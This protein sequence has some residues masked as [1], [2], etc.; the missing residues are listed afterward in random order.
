MDEDEE[1]E[2]VM[3]KIFELTNDNKNKYSDIA[4]LFR[5]NAQSRAI[6]DKLI[7]NGIPYKLHGG[8][9]F[10]DRAEI[11]DLIAYFKL[12]YNVNDNASYKR[13]YN[14]PNRYLGNAFYDMVRKG[15]SHYNTM[16][17]SQYTMTKS[18]QQG[19]MQLISIITAIQ[20]NNAN[21]QRL[22]K[23]LGMILDSGYREW[24]M[25]DDVDDSADNPKL[26]NIETLN[27]LISKFDS[28]D[29]FMVHLKRIEETR[30]EDRGNVVHLMTIHKSKG[31]EFKNVFTLGVSETILP[32]GRALEE[33]VDGKALEEEEDFA[34]LQ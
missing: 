24:L 21:K 17:E 2:Y 28:L 26:E 29:D 11:K 32:H 14:K 6:E 33:S 27:Y 19:S 23:S 12:A 22:T 4:C 16:K 20:N 8:H 7:Y 9:S 31:L 15:K 13:I 25:K 5:T 1:A 3:D 10:Y 30:K 18:F 34:T